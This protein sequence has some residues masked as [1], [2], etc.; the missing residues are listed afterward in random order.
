MCL[1]G[2][3]ESNFLCCQ[4]TISTSKYCD[5]FH[6]VHEAMAE[7]HLTVE[8]TLDLLLYFSAVDFKF[9]NLGIETSDL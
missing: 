6:Q 4:W 8:T 5:L 9:L 1:N 3:S 2:I 7:L